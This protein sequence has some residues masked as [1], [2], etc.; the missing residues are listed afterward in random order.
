LATISQRCLLPG[1]DQ[2]PLTANRR[3]VVINDLL[4]IYKP[5][6]A[7]HLHVFQAGT[8]IDFDKSKIFRIPPGPHRPLI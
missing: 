6:A 7:K 8:V 1:F 2:A 5:A 3:A 4:I